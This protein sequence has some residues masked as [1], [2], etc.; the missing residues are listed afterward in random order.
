MNFKSVSTERIIV[1]IVSLAL[2]MSALDA[3]IINTAIPAM[4]HSL[5]VNPIDLKIALISYLLSLTIFIPVSGWA[6][7]KFGIKRVFVIALIVFTASSFWC[8]AVHLI[9]E[10][11]IARSIQ[12][13]GGAFMLPLGRL[14]ILHTF[15]RHKFVEAMSAVIMVSSIGVM[16]GP[17]AGGVITDH[18]SWHWI[19]WVNI[20]FGIV[21]I[22]M[23]M[24]WLKET[25]LK[26]V[27][28]FDIL[29]FIL[30]GGG[31]AGLT[32]AMSSLSE[33]TASPQRGF[34]I[35]GISALM[36]VS[37]FLRSNTK[38]D[39][40]IHTNLFR[41]RTFR[42]SFL[43][44]LVTRLGFGGMPF[45]LPILFQV[46][47]GY[48]AQASGLLLVPIAFGII[49]VKFKSLSLKILRLLGY[50]RLL[51]INTLLLGLSLCSFKIVNEHTSIYIIT[52]LVFILGFLISLQYSGMNSLTYAEI[53]T[54]DLSGANSIFSMTQQLAQG[55]G[56]TV[57]ALLLRYYSLD[58]THNFL[59]TP[60]TFHKAFFA[61][62]F[63]TMLSS[64]VFIRLKA[65][66]GRQMLSADK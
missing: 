28:P 52:I 32:F 1:F 25:E 31:L 41:I 35:I 48:S 19:F 57:S 40:I 42:I 27:L 63:L 20:P 18:L 3:T 24:H 39:P 50:K 30:F 13:I 15:Q 4:A 60:N 51:I 7:D 47:L 46:S 22:A 53:P 36:L 56:V 55:F 54:E 17:L 44:N 58:S 38:Y 11:V 26:K 62:G 21:T 64:L 33:S 16:L 12:G 65:D 14:I 59:L 8:G 34:L 29:G 37:Y 23:A 61:M 5:K 43:G 49:L 66:D 10:L 2:F 45:L 6:A 9:S